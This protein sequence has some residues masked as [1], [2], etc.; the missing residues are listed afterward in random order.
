MKCLAKNNASALDDLEKELMTDTCVNGARHGAW[1]RSIHN[2][3]TT[4]RKKNE[5]FHE[6]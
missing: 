5:P 2:N 6:T 4:I 3:G 1:N